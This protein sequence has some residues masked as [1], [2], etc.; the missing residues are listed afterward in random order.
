[1]TSRTATVL[2]SLA[3]L[4]VTFPLA[5]LWHRVLFKVPYEEIGYIG[6]EDP[7]FVFGF[8]SIAMQGILLSLG[9]RVFAKSE[10]KVRAGS[11]RVLLDIACPGIRG[12]RRYQSP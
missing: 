4:V 6:R 2:S 10:H 5:I 8:I 12:E 7:I 3:Y 11:R 1:M 9:Y